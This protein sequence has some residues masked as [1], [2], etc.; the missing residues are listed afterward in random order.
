MVATARAWAFDHAGP[1]WAGTGLDARGLPAE[2]LTLDGFADPA[3]RRLFV[4]ARHVFSF[5]TLGRMGWTGP[6]A[7]RAGAALDHILGHGRRTDGLYIH[8]FAE[9]GVPLDTGWDLYDQG[10][11]L[12]A[13]AEAGS[14]LGR[15]DALE[16]ARDLARTL[17]R[18]AAHPAG[19]FREGERGPASPRRQNPHMHLF[20]G[21]L[22]LLEV[23]PD[24]RWQ[25]LGERLGRLCLDRFMVGGTGPVREF[26]GE[27]LTPAPGPEGRVVEPGHCCEWAWLLWRADALGLG[28]GDFAAAAE[29]LLGFARAHGTGPDGKVTLDA[30]DVDGAVLKPTAR[31]WPQTERMKASLER[32]RRGA[33]PSD[34]ADAARAFAALAPF[35]ETPC[36]GAWYDVQLPDGSFR[37]EAARGSSLYHILCAYRELM[38]LTARVL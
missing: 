37:P 28:G 3:P 17:E 26:F 16:A 13:C 23:D 21:V 19:G 30:I 25:A 35:L 4:L 14:M 31:L 22:A 2:R 11:V 36:P 24:L 18:V 12:L 32:F 1:L 27:D 34:L 5:C 38:G 9:D 33:D 20:E 15:T 6:W 8:R 10:F 29:R 7:D